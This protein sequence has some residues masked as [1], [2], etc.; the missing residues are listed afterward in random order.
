MAKPITWGASMGVSIAESPSNKFFQPLVPDNF[1]CISSSISH[2][3]YFVN[4]FLECWLSPSDLHGI[5]HPTSRLPW[6]AHQRAILTC[7]N[8]QHVQFSPNLLLETIFKGNVTD[9][10]SPL[11]FI[12]FSSNVFLYPHPTHFVKL[13]PAKAILFNLCKSQK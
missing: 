1:P 13:L 9:C 8:T 12:A 2:F 7:H 11:G 3:L 10:F 4:L 5:S 6:T